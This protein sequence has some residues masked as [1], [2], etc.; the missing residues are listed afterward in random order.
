MRIAIVDTN[1]PH[2]ECVWAGATRILGVGALPPRGELFD[3]IFVPEALDGDP[4]VDDVLAA[5]VLPLRG[6]IKYLRREVA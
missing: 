5:R 2:Y 6:V 4:W 3:V 1:L